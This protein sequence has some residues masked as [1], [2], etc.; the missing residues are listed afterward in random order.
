LRKKAKKPQKSELPKIAISQEKWSE[1]GRFYES[2]FLK[3]NRISGR[4]SGCAGPHSQRILC[5]LFHS[6][7]SEDKKSYPPKFE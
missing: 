1:K 7:N 2:P 6:S 5:G 4:V 3:K